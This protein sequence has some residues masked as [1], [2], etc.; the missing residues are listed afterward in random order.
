MS[1]MIQ[2]HMFPE[3]PDASREDYEPGWVQWHLWLLCPAEA[4][5]VCSPLPVSLEGLPGGRATHSREPLPE[6]TVSR[7]LGDQRGHFSAGE[8]RFKEL[9]VKTGLLGWDLEEG[10]G[11]VKQLCPLLCG[12]FRSPHE[13]SP[14]GACVRPACAAWR[15]RRGRGLSAGHGGGQGA[16]AFLLLLPPARRPFP[17]LLSSAWQASVGACPPG[18]QP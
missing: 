3:L 5:P 14:L 17:A 18:T 10:Q 1:D 16:A 13:H 15:H 9:L 2:P 12:A 6:H 7:K 4:P 8:I 11:A